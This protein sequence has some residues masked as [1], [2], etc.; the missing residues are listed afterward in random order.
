MPLALHLTQGDTGFPLTSP[1]VEL[2]VAGPLGPPMVEQRAGFT[3]HTV[4]WETQALVS[5]PSKQCCV[6][7]GQSYTSLGLY[8]CPGVG[9]G[10]QAALF[11]D[12]LEG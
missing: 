3:F 1:K 10:G 8:F 5:T 6:T 2:G 9:E 12:S 7:L 4:S 11:W